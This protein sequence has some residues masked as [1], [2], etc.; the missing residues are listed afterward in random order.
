MLI[1]LNGH[2]K[3]ADF[4]SAKY[5]PGCL[6]ALPPPDVEHSL[7]GTP[8]YLAPE[9]LMGVPQ[10]EVVDWWSFG[11]LCCEL[12]TGRTPFG[13][14]AEPGPPCVADL[15]RRILAL[16]LALPD[17]A[18]LGPAEQALVCALLVRDPVARLGARPGSHADVL[19]HAWFADAGITA[20][21]L[22]HQRVPPPW[23]PAAPP[24]AANAAAAVA[25][26]AP[27]HAALER[28]AA[29]HAQGLRITSTANVHHQPVAHAFATW[30]TA[31]V[32]IP[33]GAAAEGVVES[34]AAEVVVEPAEPEVGVPEPADAPP[35]VDEPLVALAATT[36]LAG[37]SSPPASPPA[38]LWAPD[39]QETEQLDAELVN[40]TNPADFELAPDATD[41]DVL[42]FTSPVT[43]TDALP[44]ERAVR[45]SLGQIECDCN[46]AYVRSPNAGASNLDTLASSAQ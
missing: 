36:D 25:A 7:I 28:M 40:T 23:V 32:L 5:Q 43:V 45:S 29:D 18:G 10:S 46:H 31:A 27:Q 38:E 6:G 33:E 9:V 1:G 8:E 44:Q 11:C 15:V 14:N 24:Q 35:E 22:L 34:A 41:T 4:G 39:D 17:H 42:N 12:L 26:A 19:A 2:V 21:D 20:D 37:P 3:L 30:G 16:P 13:G